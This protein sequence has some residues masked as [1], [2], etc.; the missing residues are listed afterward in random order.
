[1]HKSVSLLGFRSSLLNDPSIGLTI[2]SHA[3]TQS[4]DAD[5][6]QCLLG[7]DAYHVRSEQCL[8]GFR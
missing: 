1:M 6:P 4:R 5:N 2:P 8:W 3:F 7:F